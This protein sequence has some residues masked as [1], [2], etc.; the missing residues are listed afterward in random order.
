MADIKIVTSGVCKECNKK[1][2]HDD[3]GNTKCDCNN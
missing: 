1:F 2:T 3:Q